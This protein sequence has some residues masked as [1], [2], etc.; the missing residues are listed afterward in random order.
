MHFTSEYLT[1]NELKISPNLFRPNPSNTLIS[2]SHSK[3]LGLSVPEVFSEDNNVELSVIVPCYNETKRLHLFLEDAVPVLNS[4]YPLSDNESTASSTSAISLT[5]TTA[6]TLKNTL[7]STNTVSP[8]WELI[9]V[10]DG[11]SDGTAEYAIK[12]AADQHNSGK[13]HMPPGTLRVC[14]LEKNRGKGG[15]VAHGMLH[16]RGK[17]AIFADADGASKFDDVRRLLKSIKNHVEGET[18]SKDSNNYLEHPVVAIGSRAHMVKTDAVVKRSFIRNFLMYGLH[19]LVYVFGIRTIGDTQCGFK[20][21]TRSAILQIFPYM[22]NEGW[23]FDVETL[24]IAMRAGIPVMEVPI[25]WHEVAG[26]KVELAKD[27]IKMAIDLVVTRLAY[28]FGV[29]TDGVKQTKKARKIVEQGQS[30]KAN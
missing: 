22:H 15:A 28:V 4:M 7:S 18:A 20:M 12:W 14:R 30:V 6:P 5:T 27:S 25:S 1:D 26:S 19:A 29:Y 9:L 2:P 23:I 3:S 24:I 17:C 11:S 8:R 13:Y 16:V 21:Y 10:D